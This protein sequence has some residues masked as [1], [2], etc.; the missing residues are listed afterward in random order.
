[1]KT[2]LAALAV[3]TLT[4]CAQNPPMKQGNVSAYD[5]T[6]FYVGLPG[7]ILRCV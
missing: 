1:M 7:V 6:V 2:L 3:A 4:A 5:Y